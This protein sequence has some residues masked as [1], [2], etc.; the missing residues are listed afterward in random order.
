MTFTSKI[1]NCS[2]ASYLK[3][4][5]NRLFS[6]KHQVELAF[7][8]NP[9]NILI[10]GKGDG[11]VGNII[12]SSGIKVISLDIDRFLKPNIVASV[13]SMPIFDNSVDLC[14]CCEVLEHLHYDSFEEVLKEI[15]RVTKYCFI[16]SLPDIRRFFS[17]RLIAPKLKFS[18]QI[19]LPRLRKIEFSKNRTKSMGHYWEIGFKEYGFGKIANAIESAG[20]EIDKSFRVHDMQWHTFFYCKKR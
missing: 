3:T 15:Y 19:S 7:E 4:D 18:Y 5:V 17:I 13:E 6:Y 12:S 8:T 16:L 2:K 10:V 1:I 14:I 11:I 9:E 20:W